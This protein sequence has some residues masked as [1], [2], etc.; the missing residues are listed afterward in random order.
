MGSV[1]AD[2][3]FNFRV[4]V[5]EEKDTKVVPCKWYSDVK[6]Q[7]NCYGAKSRWITYLK[8]NTVTAIVFELQLIYS[9]VRT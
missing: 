1:S 8:E 3:V 6:Y 4:E 2:C 7:V 5:N 9:K